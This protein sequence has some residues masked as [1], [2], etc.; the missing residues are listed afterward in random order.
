ME[1]LTQNFIMFKQDALAVEFLHVG[2]FWQSQKQ[3]LSILPDDGIEFRVHALNNVNTV[4]VY[5]ERDSGITVYTSGYYESNDTIRV[6]FDPADTSTLTAG[7][8][9]FQLKVIY[10]GTQGVVVA[11]GSIDLQERA[12]NT[13]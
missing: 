1:K 6:Q 9:E 10:G 2:P 3:V 12:I 13:A 7:E 11:A 8:Y 5:K 4:H